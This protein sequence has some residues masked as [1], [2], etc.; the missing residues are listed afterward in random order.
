[1]RQASP[2]TYLPQ[3]VRGAEHPD[4]PRV[5]AGNPDGGQWTDGGGGVGSSRPNSIDPINT[6]STSAR[7]RAI[8][9]NSTTASGSLTQGGSWIGATLR[10]FIKKAAILAGPLANFGSPKLRGTAIHTFLKAE[11]DR[12]RNPNLRT[13]VSFLKSAY[14]TL[15]ESDE[16]NL[17]EGSMNL[18]GQVRYGKKL[19]CAST[20]TTKPPITWSVS[21]MLKPAD[22]ILLPRVWMKLPRLWPDATVTAFSF[23]LLG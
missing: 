14:A 15:L 22:M 2:N 3:D 4:Q 5:P 19:P 17:P 7:P 20:S 1:M 18:P 11:I 10:P 23:L 12:V 9:V 13:E 21:T 8:P 16:L 6:G